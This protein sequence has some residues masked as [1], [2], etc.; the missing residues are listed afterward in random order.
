MSN[1]LPIILET[2]YKVME[3]KDNPPAG[4]GPEDKPK[5]QFK[6]REEYEAQFVPLHPETGKPLKT[7]EYVHVVGKHDPSRVTKGLNAFRY[8]TNAEYAAIPKAET[9]G[10]DSHIEDYVKTL[11]AQGVHPEKARSMGASRASFGT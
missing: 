1:R 2:I 6:S 3:A 11:I 5:K 10:L 4:K 7:G 8:Y 9:P